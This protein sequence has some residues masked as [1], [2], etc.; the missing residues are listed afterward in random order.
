MGICRLQNDGHYEFDSGSN[1][2]AG[3]KQDE[4]EYDYDQMMSGEVEDILEYEK[5]EQFFVPATR[6][7]ELKEQLRR[8]QI[9][10]IL[11]KDLQ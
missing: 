9:S 1:A 11:N 3:M 6:E 2:Y 5:E 7:D 10:V 4:V 8:L